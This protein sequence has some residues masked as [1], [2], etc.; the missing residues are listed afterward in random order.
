MKIT[1][2]FITNNRCFQKNQGINPTGLMLHSVGC[3]QPKAS[4]FYKTWNKPEAKVAVHAVIDA[5]DGSIIQCLPWNLRGWHAGGKANDTHIGVEMC[6]PDCIEYTKGSKFNVKDL[7]KAQA[8]AKTAYNSA[9]ELFADLCKKYNIKPENVISHKEGNKLGI[10]TRHVDPEHLWTQLNLPYTMDTFREA[11]KA[12][13]TVV[14]VTPKPV[15]NV[16]PVAKNE[17]NVSKKVWDRLKA[18]GLTDAGVAGVMGNL[19]AESGMK[20]NNLQNSFNK[21]LN[22]TDEIY[23]Q[24]V[25]KGIYNNFVMDGAGYGLAQWTFRTRKEALLKYCRSHNKSIGDADAQIDFLIL[26]LDNYK[27]LMEILKTTKDVR[28]ASDAFLKIFEKPADMGINVQQKRLT[29]SLNYYNIYVSEHM[30]RVR[31]RWDKPN[32]QKGAFRVYANA[33]A[34][35][36]KYG[37]NVYDENGSLVYNSKKG[38]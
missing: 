30:F 38:D 10:A 32:T 1:T 16:Q 27:Q 7:A 34:L 12:K 23:T 26:E 31:E 18:I 2:Q 25:D 5:N 21:K 3:A 14:P 8:M 11:V 36:D 28:T 22:Y 15:V 29:Y 20:P 19:Y 37:L 17:V 33:K 24:L 4:V 6:E 9:V 13:L 35:A